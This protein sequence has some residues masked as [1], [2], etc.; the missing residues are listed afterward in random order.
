MICF[1]GDCNQKK[2]LVPPSACEIESIR[3]SLQPLAAHRKLTM[4]WQLTIVKGCRVPRDFMWEANF[5]MQRRKGKKCWDIVAISDWVIT[6]L[7]LDRQVASSVVG[8]KNSTEGGSIESEKWATLPP[9]PPT[10]RFF[11]LFTELCKS[12]RDVQN[13]GHVDVGS[14]H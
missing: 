10:P 2:W 4:L 13:H 3:I 1:F 11:I 7:L 5:F 8:N 6:W 12:W 14:S 9:P